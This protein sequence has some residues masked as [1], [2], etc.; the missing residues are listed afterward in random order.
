MI[1]ERPVARGR[2]GN[3]PAEHTVLK[4]KFSVPRGPITMVSRG[5]LLDSLDAGVQGPLT[6]L[7]APAGA[8]K[9]A[10]LSSWVA[11]GRAPR[12]NAWR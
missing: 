9:T 4:T 1:S 6:L 3:R 5:R 10:L 7:A 8:G 11:A 2:A 12:P